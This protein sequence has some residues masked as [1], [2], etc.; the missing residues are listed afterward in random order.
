MASAWWKRLG[1][2]GGSP[3]PPSSSSGG[4]ER[5]DAAGADT[6]AFSGTAQDLMNLMDLHDLAGT[7]KKRASLTQM[8]TG[9]AERE[10][11]HAALM[12]EWLPTTGR[13]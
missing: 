10:A 1:G 2:G 8:D 3:L 9:R 4:G 12:A 5:D 11:V 6:T 13:S 7:V